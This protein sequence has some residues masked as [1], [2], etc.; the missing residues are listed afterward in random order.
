MGLLTYCKNEVIRFFFCRFCCGL[1][2][3]AGDLEK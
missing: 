3:F 2:I 1:I